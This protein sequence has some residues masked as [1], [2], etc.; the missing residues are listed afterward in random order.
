MEGI[1]SSLCDDRGDSLEGEAARPSVE[2]QAASSEDASA[3]TNGK[4]SEAAGQSLDVV[5]RDSVMGGSEEDG[6]GN[7][8]ETPVTR[9]LS[10][11][12]V[13]KRGRRSNRERLER[14]RGIEKWLGQGGEGVDMTRGVRK[15]RKTVSEGNDRSRRDDSDLGSVFEFE[16]PW[17]DRMNKQESIIAE[18]QKILGGVKEEVAKL[19]RERVKEIEK[20]EKKMKMERDA[21]REEIKRKETKWEGEKKLLEEEMEVVERGK[22]DEKSHSWSEIVRRG[23]QT[24][25]GVKETALEAKVQ[26]LLDWKQENLEQKRKKSLRISALKWDGRNPLKKAKNFLQEKFSLGH[27]VEDVWCEGGLR[28]I[29]RVVKGWGEHTNV[30]FRRVF[31]VD[32]WFSWRQI[33]RKEHVS[34]LEQT[35]EKRCGLWE[36]IRQLD[37]VGIMETWIREDEGEVWIKNLPSEF[38]WH[39]QYAVKEQS[40]GRGIIVGNRKSVLMT[41]EVDDGRRGLVKW[42]GRGGG[43][44]WTISTEFKENIASPEQ[45]LP[46]ELMIIGGDLNAWTGEEGG[47]QG[48]SSR[49]KKQGDKEG[50]FT[51]V[52][53]RGASV[54]DYLLVNTEGWN[55]S[56]DFEVKSR[57]E[58]DHMP[59]VSVWTSKEGLK[60]EGKKEKSRQVE[61]II[62]CWDEESTRIF[63]GRTEEISLS[64]GGL[65]EKWEELRG[66]VGKAVIEKKVR[67]RK[68]KLGYKKWWDRE[69]TRKKR[70]AERKLK[71]KEAALQVKRELVVLCEKKRKEWSKRE[72]EE[73]NGI[74]TETEVW[75]YINKERKVRDKVSK[76]IPME[77]WRQHFMGVLEWT[78]ER[79]LEKERRGGNDEE[80]LT[81]DEI[82]KQIRKLRR[83][84]AAGPDG[85]RNEAWKFCKRQVRERLK[86]VIKGVWRGEGW[87]DSW[88]EGVISP[89]YKKR[90]KQSPAN[91]RGITLL[92]PAY[93]IYAAVLAERLMKEMVEKQIL[94]ETQAGFRKGRVVMDNIFILNH[95]VDR[96]LNGAGKKV[97]AFSIDL[98]GAFDR[99]RVGDR[100][101][102]FFWTTKGVRQGCPLSPLLFS[103]FISNLEKEMVRG[104]VGGMQIGPGRIWT[105]A[106]ADDI[107]LLAR[108]EEALEEMIKR[109]E[110]YLEKR[111]LELNIGKLKILKFRKG[112]GVARE[113]DW[114]WKGRKIQEVKEFEYL[115]FILQRNGSLTKHIRERVRRATLV[116]KKTWNLGERKFANNWG[117]RRML[118]DSLVGSVMVYGAEVWGWLEHSNV[119]G[120]E[121][122]YLRWSLGLEKCTPGY[123]VLEE[124]KRDKI[125][126]RTAKLAVN[127]EE[128]A[129]QGHGRR[130]WVKKCIKEREGRGTLTRG[131][132][133][134]EEYLSRCVVQ[135][136]DL[137]QWRE[138]GRCEDRERQIEEQE[139]LIEG[140]RYNKRY[141]RIKVAGLLE[142]L[143]KKGESGS[144]KRSHNRYW[145]R[146]E[147]RNCNIVTGKRILWNI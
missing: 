17:V 87:P 30:R 41:E 105:L 140:A 118:F 18:L 70:K 111:K 26:E 40:R 43:H 108:E 3:A 60:K 146:E 32:K 34:L 139:R 130:R 66:K 138:Q 126:I 4:R 25:T 45:Q 52:G 37:F 6:E 115:D 124:T 42:K 51:Y 23:K 56:E 54:I 76:E 120:V 24:K 31:L 143:R 116:M 145:L 136:V 119:E 72:M 12:G 61:R 74:R 9:F 147:E 19:K 36:F 85:I 14:E 75:K 78:D 80:D 92:S 122:R 47:V 73:L 5:D 141:R 62:Q 142:Y 117:R 144:H 2:R 10:T 81:D 125:R 88:K 50:E 35:E 59:L 7:S 137:E 49:R 110:K 8:L 113:K 93:K 109:L 57:I 44:K 106:Y 84:K 97:N 96:E 98:K 65:L 103:I 63:A 91:Y 67:W 128:K 127:F 55:L 86:E 112:R 82:K 46:E 11:A 134:R 104:L 95:L 101:S 22:E 133:E 79:I 13:G 39:V 27:L 48:W 89:L 69:C 64:E 20:L 99:V 100:E 135:D 83:G 21:L 131:R 28:G 132:S 16:G 90:D 71:S 121:A 94:P 53:A 107:V 114:Y 58:S 102:S 15:K 38:D 129:R 29:A 33:E 123:V 1:E 68:R 77:S